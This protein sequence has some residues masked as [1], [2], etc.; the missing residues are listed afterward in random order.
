M[1][2]FKKKKTK[3][4]TPCMISSHYSFLASS[5][6]WMLWTSLWNAD[7]P[8]MLFPRLTFAL[9]APVVACQLYQLAKRSVR[10]FGL[11]TGKVLKKKPKQKKPGKVK[12]RSFQD[13]LPT[14]LHS[15]IIVERASPG[16]LTTHGREAARTAS[17]QHRKTTSFSHIF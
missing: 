9:P 4:K 13:I 10:A 7:T 6:I 1:V 14:I 16:S 11:W 3:K 5:H 2:R 12:Q 17:H 8:L 15:E